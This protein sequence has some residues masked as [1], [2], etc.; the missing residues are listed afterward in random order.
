ME[1]IGLYP[2]VKE[3]DLAGFQAAGWAGPLKI[4]VSVFSGT[5]IGIE[6]LFPV[7]GQT[8]GKKGR[9]LTL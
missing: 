3:I 8:L 5:G 7:V 4:C 6:I 2:Y 9:Q 1:K